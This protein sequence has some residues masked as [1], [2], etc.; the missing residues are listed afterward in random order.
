VAFNAGSTTDAWALAVPWSCRL[1]AGRPRG[2]RCPGWPAADVDGIRVVP[3]RGPLPQ[4]LSRR[5]PYRQ[6]RSSPRAADAGILAPVSGSEGSARSGSPRPR[7]TAGSG[8]S[9]GISPPAWRTDRIR[10]GARGRRVGLARWLGWRRAAG[11]AHGSSFRS[12]RGDDLDDPAGNLPGVPHGVRLPAWLGDVAAGSEYHLGV[13]GAEADLAFEHDRGLV[14][15]GVP[16]RRGDEADRERVLEDGD[17]PAVAP[18]VD[19]VRGPESG[20]ADALPRFR[21]LPR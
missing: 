5:G 6:G 19:L 12:P 1:A 8:R 21:A 10:A 14:L 13:V 16:V 17:F 3:P 18:A 20:D 11:R 4:H 7:A 9:C 2:G 15:P